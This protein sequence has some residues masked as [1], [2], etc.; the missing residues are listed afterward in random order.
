[1][2]LT[3]AE[4][5]KKYRENKLKSTTGNRHRRLQLIIDDKTNIELS[6]IIFR[7]VRL[8]AETNTSEHPVTK[9]DVIAAAIHKYALELGVEYDPKVVTL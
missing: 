4:R 7:H 3:N 2:A 6:S 1:M 5:Q 8:N 9:Q